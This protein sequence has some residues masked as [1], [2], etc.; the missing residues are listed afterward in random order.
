MYGNG[1]RRIITRRHHKAVEKILHCN[2]VSRL[3]SA[4][5]SACLGYNRILRHRHLIR[6]IPLFKGDDGS[7]NFGS[8]GR[9]Q[10]FEC[11]LTVDNRAV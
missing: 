4:E 3:D 7:H 8:A 2:H 9:I 10:P 6:E 11:I 5:G 1:V